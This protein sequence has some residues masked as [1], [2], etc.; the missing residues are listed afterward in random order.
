MQMKVS[1]VKEWGFLLDKYKFYEAIIHLQSKEVARL[2]F[3]NIITFLHR[4]TAE[5]L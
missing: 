1:E 4:S 3:C 2:Y 5:I